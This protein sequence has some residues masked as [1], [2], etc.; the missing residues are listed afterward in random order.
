MGKNR[1]I[2]PHIALH[3]PPSLQAHALW[4]PFVEDWIGDDADVRGDWLG[5]AVIARVLVEPVGA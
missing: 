1:Y 4:C 3:S 2:P 5:A